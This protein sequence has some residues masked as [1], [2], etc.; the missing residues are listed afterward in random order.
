MDK[1]VRIAI[2]VIAIG[3][4]AGAVAFFTREK[5]REMTPVLRQL[6]EDVANQFA[7]TLPRNRDVNDLLLLVLQRG[8]RDEELEF[9]DLLKDRIRQ[10]GKY[11][12]QDWQDLKK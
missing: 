4:I 12:I 10:A 2:V 5:K 3:I 6:S 1:L 8:N 11:K 9:R 7:E